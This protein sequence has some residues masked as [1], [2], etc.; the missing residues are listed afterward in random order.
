MAIVGRI[1]AIKN[2]ALYLR[3]A[4]RVAAAYPDMVALVVG[5]GELR[6]AT[7]QL[8]VDL[9]L[10]RR[11]RFLGWRRDLPRVYADADVLVVSSNNEGTPVAAIEAMAAGC[12]VVATRVGG[13]PDLISDFETGML[14][15]PGDADRLAQA[16]LWVRENPNETRR[17]AEAARARA[18]QRHSVPSLVQAMDG[19]YRRLVSEAQNQASEA[20]AGLQRR[21]SRS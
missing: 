7:E 18:V 13:V 14:V 9:G 17:W 15:P 20:G 6:G 11:A 2:H 5:D 1:A 21:K 3:A 8:A 12:P 4:S 10:E 16:L 19:L